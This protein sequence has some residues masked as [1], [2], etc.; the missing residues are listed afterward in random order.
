MGYRTT[1]VSQDYYE[2]LPEWFV[3]KW[4]D[5]INFGEHR[6]KKPSWPISSKWE[7]K[8]YSGTDE[9]LFL[10]VA[11]ILRENTDPVWAG[12]G[13][14]FVLMHED[15]EVTKVKVEKDKISG[16]H[17]NVDEEDTSNWQLGEWEDRIIEEEKDA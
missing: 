1:F 6:N 14:E 10:D 5:Y 8:F 2:D 9:D 12:Y 17:L 3:E 7:R 16:K 4:K 13:I 15:G 11:R